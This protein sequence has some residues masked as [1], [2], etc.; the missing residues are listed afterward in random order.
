VDE[1][2]QSIHARRPYGD[3]FEI[4]YMRRRGYEEGL[5]EALA[6]FIV[7]DTARLDPVTA[8]YEYYVAAYQSLAHVFRLRARAPT[9]A[10]LDAATR[11]SP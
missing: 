9:A 1:T 11:E 5:A 8:S 6:R 2:P 7:R 10:A 4:E 3:G